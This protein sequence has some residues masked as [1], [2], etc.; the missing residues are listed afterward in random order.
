MRSLGGAR[1][2]VGVCSCSEA[3]ILEHLALPRSN[4]THHLARPEADFPV[5]WYKFVDLWREN[6]ENDENNLTE[7]ELEHQGC[8]CAFSVARWK[9]K[10]AD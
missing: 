4:W 3:F 7:T 10:I 5:L 1:E 8:S 9:R 6:R 2:G